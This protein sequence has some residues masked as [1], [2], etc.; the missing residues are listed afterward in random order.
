MLRSKPAALKIK[1]L[2]TGI[3]LAATLLWV[4]KT[5]VP[6][7]PQPVP[8]PFQENRIHEKT[9]ATGLKIDNYASGG[10]TLSMSIDRLRVV[11]KKIGFFRLGF[12]K[13]ARVEDVTLDWYE[14]IIPGRKQTSGPAE[15][16]E[17]PV[18][19]KHLSDLLNNLKKYLPGNIKGVELTPLKINYFRNQR[20]ILSI[21][22]DS[23]APG[24]QG[25]RIVFKG[26]VKLLADFEKKLKCEKMTWLIDKK[27]FVSKSSFVFQ[28]NH[29]QIKGKGFKTD[30]ALTEI[31]TQKRKKQ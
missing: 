26:N 6:E 9:I 31:I 19:S 14:G 28:D 21:H 8:A 10:K 5:R 24:H 22:A 11:K 29:H 4:I 25:Q 18:N 27:R 2:A 3:L 13:I 20:C 23:A 17:N 15:D 7:F 16:S 30:F 12:L 1:T